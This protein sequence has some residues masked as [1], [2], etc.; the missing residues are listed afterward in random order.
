VNVLPPSVLSSSTPPS[1]PR[2]GLISDASRL[3][4]CR[5]T[6]RG[7]LA[8]RGKCS[9]SSRLSLTTAGSSINAAFGAESAG[10][11][12]KPEFE[13]TQRGGGP[14][15]F[16]AIQS[17]GNLG[18][19]TASKFSINTTGSRQGGEQEGV[20]TGVGVGVPSATAM[21]SAGLLALTTAAIK[22]NTQS[23]ARAPEIVNARSGVTATVEV[24]IAFSER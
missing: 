8:A 1:K 5:N 16:V 20:G 21:P 10:G 17:V 13:V 7:E 4:L 3:K 6:R 19:V 23:A 2:S 24:L 14:C 18:G 15:R 9:E 22:K 12:G 11:A